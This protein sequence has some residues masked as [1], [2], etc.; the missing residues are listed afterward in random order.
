MNKRCP[1]QLPS[2]LPRDLSQGKPIKTAPALRGL[3]LGPDT[4]PLPVRAAVSGPRD[5][6]SSAARGPLLKEDGLVPPPGDPQ[7]PVS[8]ITGPATLGGQHCPPCPQDCELWEDG[9]HIHLSHTWSPGPGS[10]GK[11][12]NQ[13]ATRYSCISNALRQTHSIAS[14][15]DQPRGGPLSFMG[16]NV[17]V[18]GWGIDIRQVWFLPVRSLESSWKTGLGLR[19]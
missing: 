5:L 2:N 4:P 1:L 18:V 6:A 3:F 15:T 19:K 9:D 16:P 11:Q 7:S 17:V 12:L 14:H 8:L 10:P 13:L